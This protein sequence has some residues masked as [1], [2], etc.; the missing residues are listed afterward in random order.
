MLIYPRLTFRSVLI[1]YLTRNM[2][3]FN[4]NMSSAFSVHYRVPRGSALEH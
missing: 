2:D 1:S 4:C 3:V